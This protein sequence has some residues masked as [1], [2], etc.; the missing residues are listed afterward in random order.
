VAEFLILMSNE[1]QHFTPHVPCKRA[2]L[3]SDPGLEDQDV[4]YGSGIEVVRE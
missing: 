2:A 4:V 3:L 1:V